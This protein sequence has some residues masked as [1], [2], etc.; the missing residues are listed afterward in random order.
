[1]SMFSLLR[2]INFWMTKSSISFCFDE[3]TSVFSKRTLSFKILSLTLLLFMTSN[4]NWFIAISKVNDFLECF[5]E[6]NV[7]ENDSSN[8]V[9][10]VEIRFDFLFWIFSINRR[11]LLKISSINKFR[12][13]TIEFRW[14]NDENMNILN[15]SWTSWRF[16]DDEV[17]MS[18]YLIF[19]SIR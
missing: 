14:I 1:M 10:N 16:D 8:R 3:K 18:I 11:R 12:F 9:N 7:D 19:S 15:K 4:V 6:K 17:E 13:L 5:D 2:S